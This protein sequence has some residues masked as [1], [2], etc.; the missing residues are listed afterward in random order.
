LICTK[1]R[2]NTIR[3]ALLLAGRGVAAAELV[4]KILVVLLT[5]ELH[6]CSRGTLLFQEDDANEAESTDDKDGG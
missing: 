1:R 6:G 5:E 2:K 3:I 4:A